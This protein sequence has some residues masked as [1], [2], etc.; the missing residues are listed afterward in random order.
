MYIIPLH[1]IYSAPSR[2]LAFWLMLSVLRTTLNK[3]FLSYLILTSYGEQM[4]PAI[5]LI[6]PN[7]FLAEADV[8]SISSPV[9]TPFI[10]LEVI[11]HIRHFFK[12]MQFLKDTFYILITIYI[13]IYKHDICWI[14]MMKLR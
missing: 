8:I 2:I 5:R 3:A 11:S 4:P 9:S 1:C 12:L 13:Y 6:K 7:H 10:F 14:S